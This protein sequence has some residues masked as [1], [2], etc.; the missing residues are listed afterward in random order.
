MKKSLSTD[1]KF[2]L[3]AFT[4]VLVLGVASGLSWSQ[5]D[6]IAE[7]IPAS[8]VSTAEPLITQQRGIASVPSVPLA[9]TKNLNSIHSELSP[10]SWDV[11]C[12][13]KSIEE[14]SIAVSDSSDFVFIKGRLC[15]SIKDLE[16]FEILN[17]S[18]GFTASIFKGPGAGHPSYRT[19]MIKLQSGENTILIS[20]KNQLGEIQKQTIKIMRLATKI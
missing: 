3:A 8:R 14:Q 19:D 10:I 12:E 16:T 9:P 1:S 4:S 13:T 2:L 17:Q 6:D 5:N 7:M 15:E 18:N 11:S 20:Y